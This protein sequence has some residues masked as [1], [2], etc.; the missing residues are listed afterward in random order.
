M[1]SPPGDELLEDFSWSERFKTLLDP[2]QYPGTK[3]LLAGLVILSTVAGI[4]VHP[5]VLLLVPFWLYN[6]FFAKESSAYLKELRAAPVKGFRESM[7]SA[8]RKRQAK[9]ELSYTQTAIKGALQGLAFFAVIAGGFAVIILFGILFNEAD[10]TKLAMPMGEAIATAAVLAGIAAFLALSSAFADVSR[11]AAKRNEYPVLAVPYL[12]IV[13]AIVGAIMAA[14]SW[15]AWH[16]WWQDLRSQGN[17]VALSSFETWLIIGAA[18]GAVGNPWRRLVGGVGNSISFVANAS[19]RGKMLVTGLWWAAVG[20]FVLWG[21]WSYTH[22]LKPNETKD[23]WIG[24][25][26]GGAVGLYLM[27]ARGLGPAWNAISP[28]AKLTEDDFVHGR[29]R[30]APEDEAARAARGGRR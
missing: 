18:L 5:L 21:T 14:P 4:Y 13:G 7:E 11:L 27:F 10:F 6:L 15:L 26:G 28:P 22:G 16:W 24:I 2:R 29:G 19:V 8:K 23:Y 12:A 17:A 25:I 30:L 9:L 1:S 20:G 3:A